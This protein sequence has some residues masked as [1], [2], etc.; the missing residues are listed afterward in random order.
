MTLTSLLRHLRA[1]PTPVAIAPAP[2]E[3]STMSNASAK[4]ESSS[5]M[6]A[7]PS[8]VSRFLLSSTKNAPALLGVGQRLLKCSLDFS[9]DKDHVGTE[10][11]H[12][13]DLERTRGR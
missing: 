3:T 10:G 13:F 7:A 6:V 12:L 4:S 9:F 11:S 1:Y 2:S 5:P 8:Q